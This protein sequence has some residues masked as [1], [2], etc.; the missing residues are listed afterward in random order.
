MTLNANDIMRIV[1][2]AR[3]KAYREQMNKEKIIQIVTYKQQLAELDRYFWFEN[4]PEEEYIEK[5]D[6]IEK[7]LHEL[8]QEDD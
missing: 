7:L 8:E 5:F 1:K 4:M 2:M 6:V 3:Y